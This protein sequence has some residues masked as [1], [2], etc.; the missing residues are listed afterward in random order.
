M[1]GCALYQCISAAQAR[2]RPSTAPHVRT[3]QRL[4]RLPARRAERL[5]CQRQG[6]PQ[7]IRHRLQ[8]GP[9]GLQ[10]L[11]GVQQSASTAGLVWTSASGPPGM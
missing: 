5:D 3:C 9:G 4:P 7:C 1:V 11:C 6:R 2:G 8:R 10:V